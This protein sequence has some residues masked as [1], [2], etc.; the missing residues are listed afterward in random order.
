ME[1]IKL[2]E[3]EKKILAALVEEWDS[4]GE[5]GYFPFKSIANISGV[6]LKDVRRNVRSLARKG[7]AEFMKGLVDQ[8]G[9]PAGAGYAATK[10]GVLLLKACIE[11]KAEVM[12]FDDGRCDDC[13]HGR[14]CL[15]CGK[16]YRE[17]ELKNGYMQEFE[18]PEAGPVLKQEP[19]TF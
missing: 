15:K 11:C 7:L 3:K 17:H 18:Y 8:D 5:S 12:C 6:D 9:I 19:I 16:P 4:W 10:K 1:T 13:W 2:N 14:K